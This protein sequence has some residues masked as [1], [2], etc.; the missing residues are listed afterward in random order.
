MA[1]VDS[2]VLELGENKGLGWLGERGEGTGDWDCMND[3]GDS[4]LG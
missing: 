3:L 1:S 4:V 2:A